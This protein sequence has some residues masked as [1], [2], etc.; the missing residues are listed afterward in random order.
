MTRVLHEAITRREM[1]T[2][3]IFSCLEK[4]VATAEEMAAAAGVSTRTIYRYI[5]LL[6]DAGEPIMS[7][8]GVGYMMGKRKPSP[9]CILDCAMRW[10]LAREAIIEASLYPIGNEEYRKRLNDLSEAEDRLSKILEQG[11]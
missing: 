7:D 2:A 3:A 9:P 8:S 1:I 6:K 10:K 4:G 11:S 5:V